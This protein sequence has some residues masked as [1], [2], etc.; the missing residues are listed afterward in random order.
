VEYIQNY[1][2]G[3]T[4]LNEV[5]KVSILSRQAII[6]TAPSASGHALNLVCPQDRVELFDDGFKLQ[7]GCGLALDYVGHGLASQTEVNEE[8]SRVDGSQWRSAFLEMILSRNLDIFFITR[9]LPRS[10]GRSYTTTCLGWSQAR[11]YSPD[12]WAISSGR[13]TI[14]KFV[15]HYHTPSCHLNLKKSNHGA[16]TWQLEPILYPIGCSSDCRLH[17]AL[18]HLFL[19]HLTVHRALESH[20]WQAAS[21]HDAVGLSTCTRW[22]LY[23]FH[24]KKNLRISQMVPKLWHSMHSMHRVSFLVA[25]KEIT[26]S[27]E[28]DI[29]WAP[30]SSDI[31]RRL[32][33]VIVGLLLA[34]VLEPQGCG[35]SRLLPP[36]WPEVLY[37]TDVVLLSVICQGCTLFEN[38][39]NGVGSYLAEEACIV[40]VFI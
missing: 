37:A 12:C 35:G 13:D 23:D 27:C 18:Q 39:V 10:P 22:V 21:V 36:G 16:V 8:R 33:V 7:D 4:S 29:S 30:S 26:F 32:G 28:T 14:C 19:K 20:H 40:C 6:S 24:F 34:P 17:S 25:F 3:W 2:Y 38:V 15:P 31:E 5:F 9:P 1:S 11:L